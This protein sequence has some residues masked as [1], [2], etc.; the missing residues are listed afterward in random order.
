MYD[1]PSVNMSWMNPSFLNEEP[2]KRKSKPLPK[3]PQRSPSGQFISVGPCWLSTSLSNNYL[4]SHPRW[5]YHDSLSSS[6]QQQQQPIYALK[7]SS[8]FT[9]I[10]V[11]EPSQYIKSNDSIKTETQLANTTNLYD[12]HQKPSLKDDIVSPPHT[13]DDD[14][15]NSIPYSLHHRSS[16]L[17][18]PAPS[19]YSSSS[20][21]NKSILLR[22]N[23]VSTRLSS[24]M[25]MSPMTPISFWNEDPI[26]TQTPNLKDDEEK[27]EDKHINDSSFPLKT[28]TSLINLNNTATL[29]TPSPSPIPLKSTSLP[30]LQHQPSLVAPIQLLTPPTSNSISLSPSSSSTMIASSLSLTNDISTFRRMASKTKDQQVQLSYMIYLVQMASL[31]KNTKKNELR[32]DLLR[33]AG[34]WLNKLYKSKCPLVL[35]MKGRWHM[36]QHP[37]HMTFHEKERYFEKD[38]ISLEDLNLMMLL[39]SSSPSSSLSSLSSSSSSSL[40]TSSYLS[41]L[42]SSSTSHSSSK[43]KTKK[44]QHH[45]P[46]KK[47]DIPLKYTP[48]AFSSINPTSDVSIIDSKRKNYHYEKAKQC[49]LLVIKLSQINKNNNKN[50]KSALQQH[51]IL[52][53]HYFMGILLWKKYGDPLKALPYFRHAAEHDHILACYKLAKMLLYEKSLVDIKQGIAFLQKAAEASHL[54]Q[55]ILPHPGAK[56]CYLLS[57]IYSGEESLIGLNRDSHWETIVNKDPILSKHYLE[58]AVQ[59]G[60][61]DAM[62]HMG[63]MYE[64]K[65]H[66]WEAFQW[67]LHAIELNQHALAMF[68]I[69]K[70]YEKGIPG[71]LQCNPSLA[72][73]WCQKAS[74]QG[75]LDQADYL[76]GTYYEN[77]FGTPSDYTKALTYYD[78]AASKGYAPAAEL[79]NRQLKRNVSSENNHLENCRS[80]STTISS[81]SPNMIL[82]SS[83]ERPDICTIM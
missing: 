10:T 80:S 48:S 40:P 39:T 18:S 32:L 50:K 17:L 72:F 29:K 81:S 57:C 9:S 31:Y 67:Y 27:D 8:L 28:T 47:I 59:L 66:E 45:H 22:S 37:I 2:P 36:Q 77:G 21:C 46:L 61:V 83:K 20:Q 58:K 49:F 34:Y 79:L 13:P 44:N 7:K 12:I 43:A 35:M 54:D 56:P 6:Q 16:I 64:K 5:S 55:D 15:D 24:P 65:G 75:D 38:I 52:D 70:W 14:N 42:A 4:D 30:L 25:N 73:K 51:L 33:E 53:A 74:D 11:C 1:Q 26:Y 19:I 68:Y 76:L 71:H 60:N 63:Q 41:L 3:I 78:K 23:T 82:I 62:V 69:S